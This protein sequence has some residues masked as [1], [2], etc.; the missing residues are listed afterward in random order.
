MNKN[1]GTSISRDTCCFLWYTNFS[2]FHLWTYDIT[3]TEILIT[4]N[5][6]QKGN[7]YKTIIPKTQYTHNWVNLNLESYFGSLRQ[8]NIIISSY[9]HIPESMC[10]AS[11][12][13]H[14]TAW[15]TIKHHIGVSL[16]GGG[17]AGCFEFII[18]EGISN[19]S[20]SWQIVLSNCWNC[21]NRS[22][23]IP[24]IIRFK[25]SHGKIQNFTFPTTILIGDYMIYDIV[26]S[27]IWE[28]IAFGLEIVAWKT[29]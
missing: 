10:N 20:T 11:S 22:V 26:Q 6:L 3:T 13:R 8:C 28:W 25:W 5:C 17:S 14:N 4:N 7:N 18:T 12:W 9:A 1:K 15:S 27:L 24:I 16:W 19:S 23:T 2:I 29:K 21:I